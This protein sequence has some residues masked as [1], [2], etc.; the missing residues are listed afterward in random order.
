MNDPHPLAPSPEERERG[1][2]SLNRLPSP[3]EGPGTGNPLGV[4]AAGG[5]GYYG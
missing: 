5:E 2:A 3:S 1:N 4:V